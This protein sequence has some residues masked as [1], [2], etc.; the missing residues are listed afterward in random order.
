M[1]ITEETDDKFL[2]TGFFPSS[3][4]YTFYPCLE[5]KNKNA[6]SK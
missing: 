2:G 1:D 6:T 3:D 4:L 5:K